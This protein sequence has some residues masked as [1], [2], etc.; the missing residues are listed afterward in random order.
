MKLTK[1]VAAFAIAL[2]G[3]AVAAE[4]FADRGHYRGHYH[5]HPRSSVQFGF[6]LG[7]PA[8]WYP[9]PYYA[10]YAYPYYYPPV[11]VQQTPPVY[12]EQRAPA[13]APPA[14]AAYWYYCPNSQAYYPYVSECAGPWQ[15]VTPQPPPS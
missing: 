11:V 2:L 9:G 15:Q 6:T 13:A 14:A 7:G 12:V 4:A 1:I 8:F 3:T 10:P 5:G